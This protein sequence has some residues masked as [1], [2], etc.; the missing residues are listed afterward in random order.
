MKLQY[1]TKEIIVLRRIS[2]IINSSDLNTNLNN[3]IISYNITPVSATGL[4]IFNGNVSLTNVDTNIFTFVTKSIIGGSSLTEPVIVRGGDLNLLYSFDS[5]GMNVGESITGKVKLI[6]SNNPTAPSVYD[7]NVIYTHGS[8]ITY[9]GSCDVN[10]LS[11]TSTSVTP[12]LQLKIYN[13]GQGSV[14]ASLKTI[15]TCDKSNSDSQ[16]LNCNITMSAS[17]RN[18]DIQFK[19]S[20]V[21]SCNAP[22]LSSTKVGDNFVMSWQ[23]DANCAYYVQYNSALFGG[24]W[25]NYPGQPDP[26]LGDGGV[27]Q[28]VIPID[29]SVNVMLL[30]LSAFPCA[31]GSCIASRSLAQSQLGISVSPVPT[32]EG[33]VT[34]TGTGCPIGVSCNLMFGNNIL[35]N[36]YSAIMVPGTYEYIYSTVGGMNSS[37]VNYTSDVVKMNVTVIVKPR[38]PNA[39]S[40]LVVNSGG[41][42]ALKL[43]WLDNS[44]NEQGF[45][46]ERTTNLGINF[47]EIARVSA[48][49]TSY[50]NSALTNK[51]IYYY[52]IYAYNVNG[53]SPYSNIANGTALN[54]N[55]LK[56]LGKLC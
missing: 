40:N 25:T 5:T 19:K 50:I 31:G 38:V 6:S 1:R 12:E 13:D 43:N 24:T 4:Q 49:T 17:S 21:V 42:N 14:G 56:K 45:V 7:C 52:K 28:F 47:A 37:G 54:C 16:G 30:R 39:P 41:S 29:Y 8:G 55:F 10:I 36:P 44:N 2:W 48:G 34:I 33:N 51:Q 22:T 18:L 23:S 53:T 27:L 32:Y 35:P 20:N 46:I 9:S 3:L 15:N 11:S 26:L